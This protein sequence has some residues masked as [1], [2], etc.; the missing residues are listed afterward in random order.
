MNVLN[1]ENYLAFIFLEASI[2]NQ[3]YE[4]VLY[5]ISKYLS[6]LF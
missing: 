4:A 5:E 2:R 1:V 6:F 3:A